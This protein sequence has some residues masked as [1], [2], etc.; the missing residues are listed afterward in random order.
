MRLK[1]VLLNLLSNACKFTQ[2]G[3]VSLIVNYEYKL[4][5]KL[6]IFEVRDTGIGIS[7]DKQAK[8]FDAFIQADSSTTREFG[9]TG[10]G[11]A[12]TKRLCEM[13]M[14]EIQVNSKP[15]SG[16]CFIIKIPEGAEVLKVAS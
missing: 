15:G 11:L 8:V 7:K 9:G 5:Q 2:N 10:L 13:M 4:S 1:Q 16:T 3:Q 12:I 6:Y 14:G